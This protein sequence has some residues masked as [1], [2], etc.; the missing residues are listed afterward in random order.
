MTNREDDGDSEGKTAASYLIKT[1]NY[2]KFFGT[3]TGRIVI[4]NLAQ[5]ILIK[6]TDDEELTCD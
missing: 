5:K 1:E 6:E 2:S 3:G 4:Q